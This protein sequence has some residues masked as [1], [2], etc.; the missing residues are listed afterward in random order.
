MLPSLSYFNLF[1]IFTVQKIIPFSILRFLSLRPWLFTLASMSAMF[2]ILRALTQISSMF[3]L[4]F[5][6]SVTNGL[7]VLRGVYVG[8]PWFIFM[9]FYS[10]IL[11]CIV[12]SLQTLKIFKVSDLRGLPF[13]EG[14]L[15]GLQFLNLGGLP[16]LVGFL[17]K[18]IMIKQLA[19]ISFRIIRLL[20]VASILMLYI[21][22]TF[23]QQIYCFNSLNKLS[24]S[25]SATCYSTLVVL[26]GS[27]LFM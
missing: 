7:W 13:S 21:Y 2:F 17:I 11:F 14:L 27:G 26:G 1:L 23:A 9:L 3:I 22:V 5:F 24:A 19:L 15:L 18:L 6:S 10:V 12:F 20:V 25:S 8:S 4:I 16:P